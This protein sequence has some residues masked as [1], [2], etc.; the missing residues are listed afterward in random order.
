M[1]EIRIFCKENIK[2]LKIE[3]SNERSR[4]FDEIFREIITET[5]KYMDEEKYPDKSK[6]TFPMYKVVWN[7]LRT[8][9]V[10]NIPRH[11]PPLCLRTA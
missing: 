6:G 8:I 1:N 5:N 3:D 2:L 7:S 10:S 11:C 4:K 9:K